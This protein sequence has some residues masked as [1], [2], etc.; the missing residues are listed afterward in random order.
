[1]TQAS[2]DTEHIRHLIERRSAALSAKA[3]RQA[4]EAYA[5]DAVSFDL[6]PPLRFVGPEVR[7][8][9]G[10]EA[11]FDTWAGPIGHETRDLEVFVDG[12]VAYAHSLVH[13]TGVRTDGTHTDVW[14]RLTLG[15]RRL[16]GDWKIAH[17]HASVPFY[18]DGSY[19]AAVDLKP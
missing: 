7:N 1:M 16:G 5:A 15:F 12:D 2:N 6:Q 14:F 9:S 13:L 4:L 11:W 19:R 3:S 8:P 10:L 18:M 17:E